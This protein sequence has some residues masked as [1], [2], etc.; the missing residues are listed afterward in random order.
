MFFL[1][2]DWLER[3]EGSD[4]N[5]SVLE[6]VSEPDLQIRTLSI[7]L[8]CLDCRGYFVNISFLSSLPV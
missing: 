7:G 8:D 6:P 5:Y 3:L 4:P 1:T 2:L